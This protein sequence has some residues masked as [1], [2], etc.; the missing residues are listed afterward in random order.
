MEKKNLKNNKKKEKK[1]NKS[2]LHRPLISLQFP[3]RRE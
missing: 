2:P 3:H 1:R